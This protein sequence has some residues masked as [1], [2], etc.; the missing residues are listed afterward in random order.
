MLHDML[1]IVSDYTA[2]VYNGSDVGGPM[3]CAPTTMSV[4]SY[5]PA[6]VQG[7][8]AAAAAVRFSTPMPFFAPGERLNSIR[9][10]V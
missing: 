9:A 5:G 2:S 4:S 3:I 10:K 8:G 1:H 7:W 6:A